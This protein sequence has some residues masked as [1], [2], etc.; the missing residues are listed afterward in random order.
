MLSAVGTMESSMSN[1][2]LDNRQ[3][4]KDGEISGK[5]RN[6]LVRMLR[7]IYGKGFAAGYPETTQLSEAM[8]QLNEPAVLS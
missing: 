2:G 5:Y 3:R 4:N 8:L 6:T 1:A 7:K